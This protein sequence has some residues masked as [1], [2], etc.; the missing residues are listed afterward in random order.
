MPWKEWLL[1]WL[2]LAFAW[3]LLTE[4]WQRLP[5]GKP[6]VTLLDVGQGD[7][8]LITTP[9]NQRILIDGGPDLSLLER[10]GEEFPFF[11]RRIDLLVLTHPDEDHVTAFPE[12]LQRY[13]V[14]QVLLTG[15]VGGTSRYS[16]FLA[17]LRESGVPVILAEASRDFDFGAGVFL[18]VLWP[19]RRSS[20]TIQAFF[21]GCAEGPRLAFFGCEPK[22][23]NDT[24]IVAKILFGD[25]S[26]LLTGDITEEVEDALWKEGLDLAAD[27]LKVPHHGSKTSSST[28]FLLAVQPDL[29]LISVGQKNRYGHPHPGV[30]ARYEAL[31]IPVRRTDEEGT[32]DLTFHR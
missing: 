2:F 27:V 17:T 31:G 14:G 10:L 8:I 6:R 4:E 28:G 22:R 26:L 30:L 23:T 16:A 32:I 11:H 7:A 1:A 3:F 19:A 21:R 12:V 9:L 15:V 25:H 20:S 5:E 29:A 18:D 24:S 13:P